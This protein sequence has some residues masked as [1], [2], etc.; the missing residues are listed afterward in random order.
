[1]TDNAGIT[2]CGIGTDKKKYYYPSDIIDGHISEIEEEFLKYINNLVT[3]WGAEL[4]AFYG[5]KIYQFY[6]NKRQNRCFKTDLS[7][8]NSVFYKEKEFTDYQRGCCHKKL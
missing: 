1:M 2:P 8:A 4:G 7:S 6:D 5:T 3:L